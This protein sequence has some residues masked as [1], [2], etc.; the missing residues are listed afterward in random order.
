MLINKEELVNSVM[1][2]VTVTMRPVSEQQLYQI[3]S[4]PSTS[5]F[6]FSN[7]TY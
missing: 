4:I 6:H 5:F 7:S 2:T 1:D 3:P